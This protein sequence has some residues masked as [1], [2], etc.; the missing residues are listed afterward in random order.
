MKENNAQTV[1]MHSFYPRS[2]KNEMCNS[3]VVFRQQLQYKNI[4]DIKPIQKLQQMQ[5]VALHVTRK[6]Y[7]TLSG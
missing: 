4:S 1:L 3:T 7:F 5:I 6:T 2:S